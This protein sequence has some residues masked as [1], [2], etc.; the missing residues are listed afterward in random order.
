MGNKTIKFSLSN[1]TPRGGAGGL[2]DLVVGRYTPLR[3]HNLNSVEEGVRIEKDTS[4][5][6]SKKYMYKI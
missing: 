6:E 3:P 1:E 2:H 4:F 5:W